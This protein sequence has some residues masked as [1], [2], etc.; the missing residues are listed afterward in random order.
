MFLTK[1]ALVPVILIA[2][3]QGTYLGVFYTICEEYVNKQ[4]TIRACKSLHIS[5]CIVLTCI[6][7]CLCKHVLRCCV[8]TATRSIDHFQ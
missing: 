2:T 5:L 3:V 4:H 1:I 7:W 6:R 8:G